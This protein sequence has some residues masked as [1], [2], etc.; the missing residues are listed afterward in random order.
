[1]IPRRIMITGA[2]ATGKSTFA[3]ILANKLSLP[4]IH[5]DALQRDFDRDKDLAEIRQ[6][7]IDEASKDAWVI[8][9]NAFRKDLDFRIV[10]ADLVIFFESS[11]AQSFAK[12]IFRHL[13][14]KLTGKQKPGG[15]SDSLR[16]NW[17]IKFIFLDWPKREKEVLQLIELHQKKLIRIRNRKEAKSL[18]ESI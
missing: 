10:R 16:L 14:H 1:M 12:H 18:L 15:T 6:R 5:L 8:D 9:G 4:I 3:S 2:V 7:I 17:F 11:P 13:H